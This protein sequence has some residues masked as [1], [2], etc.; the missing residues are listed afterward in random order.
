[1][2][3]AAWMM[4]SA[5]LVVAAGCNNNTTSYALR[6]GKTLEAIR[7]QDRLNLFLGNPAEDK[8]KELGVFVRP[9]KPLELAKA[10]ALTSNPE[11]FDAEASFAGAP[12]KD[13]SPQVR[14][15]I[16]ARKKTAKKAP[17]KGQ[18]APA[19]V[20]KLP[21]RD[22]ILGLLQNDLGGAEAIATAKLKGTNHRKNA[23]TQVVYTSAANG[24][25]IR[26]LL[27]NKDSYDIALL[28]DIPAAKL[29]TA[30]TGIDLC[31][32]ALAVGQRA[33]RA[34]DTGNVDDAPAKASG[35]GGVF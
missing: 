9:P 29:K 21:F 23:Y 14:L 24:D 1:M 27:Y 13:G 26:A 25:Q 4:L 17:P 6:M 35:G 19:E 33:V 5:A 8:L 3:R 16:L 2:K 30:G 12:A 28:F 7:Y 22:L 20:A 15:H 18:A 31:L 10:F 32:E 34:F 11:Q